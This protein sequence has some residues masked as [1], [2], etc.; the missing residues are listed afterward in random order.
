MA[1]AAFVALALGLIGYVV[2]NRLPRLRRFRRVIIAA[3]VLLFVVGIYID[4]RSV[5]AAFMDGWSSVEPYHR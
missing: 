5:A 4:R 3:G 1:D 2:T